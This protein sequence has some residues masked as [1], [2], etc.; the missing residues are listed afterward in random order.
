MSEPTM[1][2]LGAAGALLLS[3]CA[4]TPGF[5][6]LPAEHGTV[7]QGIPATAYELPTAAPRGKVR[8]ASLGVQDLETEEGDVPVL[9]TRFH[10]ANVSDDDVWRFDV[11]DVEADLGA[12][13]AQ[14]PAFV[15][16]P[17]N[18][19][20]RLTVPRGQE[21]T[22]DIFFW[23]PESAPDA[24]SLPGFHLLW[25]LEVGL[26]RLATRTPFRRATRT[27]PVSW[28]SDVA[29]S[30]Y[31]WYDPLLHGSPYHMGG[32]FGPS[33]YW[34]AGYSVG[35]SW[36]GSLVHP[37]LPVASSGRIPAIPRVT[38]LGGLPAP[39]RSPVPAWTPARPH[40]R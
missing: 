12:A 6:Y 37:A 30:A 27:D 29:Y 1:F 4:T 11:R 19:L 16:A 9:R 17:G 24:A 23:L 40:L 38:S 34:G 28:P 22:L 20:P 13:G 39:A 2:A 21:R 3:G 7:I 15:N 31:W 14:R 26:E 8:V 25:E 36:Y 32:P 5:T 35:A 10:V 33:W 18:D